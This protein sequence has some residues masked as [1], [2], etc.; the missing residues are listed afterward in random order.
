MRPFSTR[1][2]KTLIGRFCDS[3]LRHKHTNITNHTWQ[4]WEE[5][6]AIGLQA[7]K[8]N[9]AA[10]A[11]S[12]NVVATKMADQERASLNKA[13][14]RAK[15]ARKDDGSSGSSISSSSNNNGRDRPKLL[16]WGRNI[17]MGAPILPQNNSSSSSSSSSSVSSN[18]TTNSVSTNSSTTA[19][20]GHYTREVIDLIMDDSETPSLLEV[21][22]F[23][24]PCKGK[25]GSTANEGGNS[26]GGGRSTC[27]GGSSIASCAEC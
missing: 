12:S 25:G 21:T 9:E 19:L 2:Q 5:R 22:P 15:R 17:V 6:C 1:I 23:L 8:D 13:S 16:F 7:K 18:S 20:V 14:P 27:S 4:E 3:S 24:A 10:A 26:A 11:D